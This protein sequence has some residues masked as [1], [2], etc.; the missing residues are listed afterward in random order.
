[1]AQH[2]ARPGDVIRLEPF[3]ERL[4]EQ[5]TT[6]LLKAGQ[7]E[8]VRIVLLAGRG[9]PEHR[10]P[11][12]ITVLCLEGRIAF[13]T[14]AGCRTLEPGD[15][16]HLPPLEPHALTALE[17]ASALVTLCLVRPG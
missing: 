1:M 14:P 8:L 12:E 11:G 5:R 13:E 9:L 4:A 7:L 17:D 6:A 15:L 16:I 2:H 3:G 10:A